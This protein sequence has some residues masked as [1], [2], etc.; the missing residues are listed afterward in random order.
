VAVKKIIANSTLV[1]FLLT[2]VSAYARKPLD[3]GSNIRTV[4]PSGHVWTDGRIYLCL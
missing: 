1:F 4:D 2:V 3:F